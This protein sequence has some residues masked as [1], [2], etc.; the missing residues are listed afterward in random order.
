MTA[1]L[2]RSTCECVGEAACPYKTE[3]LKRVA[4]IRQRDRIMATASGRL[5]IISEILTKDDHARERPVV[6]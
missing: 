5:G 1:V 6:F 3:V 4:A 2:K